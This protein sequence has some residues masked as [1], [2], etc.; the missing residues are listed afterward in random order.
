[1]QTNFGKPSI[2]LSTGIPCTVVGL[3]FYDGF[4]G[5]DQH[6]RIKT[7]GSAWEL[8][9]VKSLQFENQ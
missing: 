1:M 4:H 3:G 2:D 6:G 5:P 8:H 7:H 9:P